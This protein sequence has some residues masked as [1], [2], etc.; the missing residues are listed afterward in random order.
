MSN[1][2][3][4]VLSSTD[5]VL[6]LECCRIGGNSTLAKEMYDFICAGAEKADAPCSEPKLGLVKK[7]S[8]A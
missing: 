5:K 2:F 3:E 1:G 4:L 6:R 7:P 8:G